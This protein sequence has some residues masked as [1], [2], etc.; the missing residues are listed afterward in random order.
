MSD[1]NF[2]KTFDIG[3]ILD[4]ISIRP[5]QI[6]AELGCGHLGHFVFP[7]AKLVGPKGTLYA[8]DIIPGTLDEIKK[9]AY[10]ENLPQIQT[11]WT[12]LEIFKGAKIES[13]SVDTALLINV[14][15][16]SDKKLDILREG[17]RLLKAG[18]RLVVADWKLDAPNFGPSVEKRLRPTLFEDLAIKSG[19]IVEEKFSAGDYYHAFI[20]KKV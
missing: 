12:D 16:Q 9:Q 18:G 11:V 15:S 19:L 6:V 14:L 17:A 13:A 4:K 3:L 1:K 5:G 7:I 10:S 20:L 8:V 2:R